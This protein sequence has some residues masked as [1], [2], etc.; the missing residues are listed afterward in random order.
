[1]LAD[2][3]M[4]IG[5]TIITPDGKI[6]TRH[7][8]NTWS[9]SWASTEQYLASLSPKELEQLEVDKQKKLAQEQ[10]QKV[11]EGCSGL[12]QEIWSW[13]NYEVLDIPNDSY[14]QLKDDEIV[15][16]IDKIVRT[17]EGSCILEI[18]M[19]NLLGSF[20]IGQQQIVPE[21]LVL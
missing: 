18:K 15:L 1:M 7:S 9:T 11:I 17:Y 3:N 12:A 14:L 2:Y 8:E 5:Q 13:I 20:V 6:I 16:G 4:E 21:L 19:M 10:R